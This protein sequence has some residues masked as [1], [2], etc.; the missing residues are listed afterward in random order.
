MKRIVVGAWIALAS[1]VGVAVSS[2]Q[3]PARQLTVEE[4]EAQ[5]GYNLNSNPQITQG[6]WNAGFSGGLNVGGGGAGFSLYPSVNY[7]PWDNIQV[8]AGIGISAQPKYSSFGLTLRGRYHFSPIRQ[9]FVPFAGASIGVTSRRTS[10]D[11]S[12]DPPLDSSTST[13]AEFSLNGGMLWFFTNQNAVGAA[14]HL[15]AATDPIFRGGNHV[16]PGLQFFLAYYFPCF[17]T[18][19]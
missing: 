13:Y 17:L 14:L 2:G 10:A 8:G 1:M 6:S 7:F 4:W 18:P 9:G 12:S 19:R 5:Y 3:A 16:Q 11:S 15:M